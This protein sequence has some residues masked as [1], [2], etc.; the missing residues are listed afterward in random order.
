MSRCTHGFPTLFHIDKVAGNVDLD[1][2]DRRQVLIPDINF[3]CNGSITRLIVGAQWEGNTGAYTELQIWRRISEVQYMKVNG[4]SIMVSG[5]NA[6][7]V[8]E[9]EISLAFLEGD[10]LG[11]FQ[12]RSFRSQLELYLEDSDRLTIHHTRLRGMDTIPPATGAI[13]SVDSASEDTKYPLIG[14][15][16]GKY[17]QVYISV[18]TIVFHRSSRLQ[19]W[20]HVCTESVCPTWNTTTT[21][22]NQR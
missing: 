14:V 4:A 17:T 15:R 7:Q 19:L 10:I 5:E 12:P 6:S 13:F 2:L 9:L 21:D 1:T 16:T 8:Y 3:S 20:L 22:W 18:S 11:Y